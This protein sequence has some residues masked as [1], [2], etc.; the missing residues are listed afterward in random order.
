M[1]ITKK[2]IKESIRSKK[3]NNRFYY[4]YI[5]NENEKYSVNTFRFGSK[6]AEYITD[7]IGYC[8]DVAY[9]KKDFVNFLYEH[10]NK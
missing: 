4:E 3:M 1:K 7:E 10:L 8:Y 5:S 6:S 9:T 2:E